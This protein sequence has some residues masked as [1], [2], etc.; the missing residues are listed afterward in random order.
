MAHS[1]SFLSVLRQLERSHQQRERNYQKAR[2]VQLRAQMQQLSAEAAA[3]YNQY[4]SELTGLHTHVPDTIDWTQIQREE[5]PAVPVATDLHA[6]HATHA[7][8]SYQPNFLDRI[9]RRE[10]KKRHQLERKVLEGIRKDLHLYELAR[11]QHH[12]QQTTWER[13]QKL[14]AAVLQHDTNAYREV[15]SSFPFLE[16]LEGFAEI[17]VIEAAPESVS[18]ELGVDPSVLIPAEALSLTPSGKLLKK[19]MSKSK[20]NELLC[21]HCC[22][23]AIYIARQTAARLPV[24]NIAVH[25]STD[26]LNPATGI[27]SRSTIL[28]VI[29]YA[30]ILSLID[31]KQVEPVACVTSSTHHMRFTKSGGFQPVEP[32]D[33]QLIR[34]SNLQKNHK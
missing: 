14:A 10:N 21:A 13:M 23:A 33:I 12:D 28:S 9:F 27:T 25:V 4:I 3:S 20:A 1:S 17:P 30:D 16:K 8:E 32:I 24:N 31:F 34:R 2:Q 7:K 11:Q 15:A 6:S 29:F 18:W 19:E 22:S 5:P 26:L